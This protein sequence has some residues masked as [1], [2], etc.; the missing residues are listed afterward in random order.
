MNQDVLP[1]EDELSANVRLE[2]SE[3]GGHV[4]FMQGS[5]WRPKIWTHKRVNDFIGN[6]LVEDTTHRQSPL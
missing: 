4:G 5:P 1:R 3:K 6:F 2:I